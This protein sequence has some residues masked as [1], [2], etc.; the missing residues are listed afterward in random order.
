MGCTF[1]LVLED[2]HKLFEVLFLFV[3]GEKVLESLEGCVEL[4]FLVEGR[5]DEVELEGT[6]AEHTLGF[7]LEFG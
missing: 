1:S 7:A 3:L 4:F 2:H 6:G 5:V